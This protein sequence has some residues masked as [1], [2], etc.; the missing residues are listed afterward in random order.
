MRVIWRAPIGDR[1]ILLGTLGTTLFWDLRFVLPVGLALG[2]VIFIQRVLG[3]LRGAARR[4]GALRSEEMVHTR[5]LPFEMPEGVQMITFRGAL[6][7]GTV[8]SLSDLLAGAS[9]ER[10]ACVFGMRNVY[11]IDPTACLLLQD[12]ARSLRES[13]PPATSGESSPRSPRVMHATHFKPEEGIFFFPDA[14]SAVEAAS[15]RA[16][17][18][19]TPP[20][21]SMERRTF[22][23]LLGA[24]LAARERRSSDRHRPAQPAETRERTPSSPLG[25]PRLTPSTTARWS[26]TRWRSATN[27]TR[28]STTRSRGPVTPGSRAPC[29]ARTSRSRR[30]RSPS[31]AVAS[32]RTPTSWCT[33]RRRR[34]SSRRSEG[35]MAVVFGFQNATMLEGVLENLDPLHEL[36][37]RCIQ[38]TYNSQNRLGSGCTERVDGGLSDF[39]SRSSSG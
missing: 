8:S 26:L 6:F 30:G 23:G 38:L 37:T 18:W 36:G 32:A 19:A 21:F 15:E 13:G 5:P 9:D 1:I 35:K 33:P 3:D 27:G 12:L 14:A 28:W 16:G 11:F 24:S 10:P 20:D 17:S 39:G 4:R 31:G 2:A 25:T 34:T 22:L 29:R 7:Y